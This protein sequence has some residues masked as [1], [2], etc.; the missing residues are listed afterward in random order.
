NEQ[1]Y[2][3]GFDNRQQLLDI[4]GVCYRLNQKTLIAQLQGGT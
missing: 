2:L 4:A 1:F 3:V